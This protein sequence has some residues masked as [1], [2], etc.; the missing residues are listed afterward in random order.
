MTE[1]IKKM[2]R[3]HLVL[4]VLIGVLAPFTTLSLVSLLFASEREIV[5]ALNE[6]FTYCGLS[7]IPGKDCIAIYE[8]II[9]NTGMR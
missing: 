2:I 6:V 9:G 3:E 1:F 4:T 7:K 5:Y 8:F